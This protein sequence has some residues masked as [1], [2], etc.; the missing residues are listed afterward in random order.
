MQPARE[1]YR[2]VSD[3]IGHLQRDE[4]K[5]TKMKERESGLPR[6]VNT[7]GTSA[8]LTSRDKEKQTMKTFTRRITRAQKGFTLIELL[9]V[10]AILAILVA[11]VA[12]NMIDSRNSSIESQALTDATTVR[13]AANDFFSSINES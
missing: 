13:S 6:R 8:T 3:D 1:H 5:E 12:P 11:G 4:V 10:M 7:Q 9:A 2:H